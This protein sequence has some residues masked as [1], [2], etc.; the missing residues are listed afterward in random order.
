MA[1]RDEFE[2]SGRQ[3]FSP[4]APAEAEVMQLLQACAPAGQAHA[5]EGEPP[6]STAVCPGGRVDTHQPASFSGAP[7]GPE[8]DTVEAGICRSAGHLQP[9][10]SSGAE[11]GANGWVGEAG[12]PCSEREARA[13]H[14]PL[15]SSEPDQAP[16]LTASPGSARPGSAAGEACGGPSTPAEGDAKAEASSELPRSAAAGMD[17]SPEEA[18]VAGTPAGQPLSEASAC[19]GLQEELQH[20]RGH[21]R[22][23]DTPAAGRDQGDARRHAPLR[24]A[25]A[26]Y[27]PA[28]P[29]VRTTVWALAFVTVLL[30]SA[31]ACVCA[32]TAK[33][34]ERWRQHHGAVACWTSYAGHEVSL[35]CIGHAS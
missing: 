22:V 13:H 23:E 33:V 27:L 32:A 8:A 34:R 25:E 3:F 18:G 28:N 26:G 31:S 6:G 11:R 14:A 21:D 15:A 29:L 24:W 5:V 9:A 17:R 19:S 12:C 35:L 20:G 16:G 10:A 1:M 30:C 4:C 7:E 2:L